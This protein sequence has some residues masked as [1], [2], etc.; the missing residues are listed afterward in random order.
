MVAALS[1]FIERKSEMRLICVTK[2]IIYIPSSAHV[3]SKLYSSTD[4]ENLYQG[5]VYR[6]LPNN[7]RIWLCYK[8][9]DYITKTV[10][11]RSN[12]TK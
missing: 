3:E 9:P 8:P 6:L 5:Y 7:E 1:L 10:L 2:D 12:L 11:S 4:D